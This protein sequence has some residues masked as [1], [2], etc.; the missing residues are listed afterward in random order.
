[1][2]II[3]AEELHGAS[4]SNEGGGIVIFESDAIIYNKYAN[5]FIDPAS[6]LQDRSLDI[7]DGCHILDNFFIT[8][9]S[10]P[11]SINYL[12]YRILVGNMK[13]SNQ[14]SIIFFQ[15]QPVCL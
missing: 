12:Q 8:I 4:K 9:F 6:S 2:P 15:V 3:G 1:L 13:I 10:L 7:C 5:V 11:F 14:S